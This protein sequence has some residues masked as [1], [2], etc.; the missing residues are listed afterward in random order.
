MIKCNVHTEYS[1]EWEIT[2]EGRVWAC[3]VFSNAWDKRHDSLNTETPV[4]KTDAVVW[5]KMQLDPNWN[6][7]EFHT[8]D[9]IVNHPIYQEYISPDGFKSTNPS[10]VCK[11]NCSVIYD[12]VMERNRSLGDITFK[13][14]TKE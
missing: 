14:I 3:C 1:R 12:A 9:E 8:L 13:K 6:S 4:L 5:A 7:L 10:P 2:P 11:K